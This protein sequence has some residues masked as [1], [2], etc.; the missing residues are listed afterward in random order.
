MV[1]W[2]G[3]RARNLR[4]ASI[5]CRDSRTLTTA[6][7]PLSRAAA[8]FG[9]AAAVFGAAAAVFGVAA[10]GFGFRVAV[11]VFG[12]RVA[13]FGFGVAAARLPRF[14]AFGRCDVRARAIALDAITTPYHSPCTPN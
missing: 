6:L 3:M 5:G 10:A 7:P 13:A 1:A 12:F 8:G 11:A 2:S 14:T 9:A 4:S